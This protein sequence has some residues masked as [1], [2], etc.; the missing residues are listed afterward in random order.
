M[1]SRYN[2][3]LRVRD[4]NEVFL[5]HNKRGVF[6][7]NIYRMYVKDRFHI[8]RSTFFR[9]LTIPYKKKLGSIDN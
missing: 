8:S 3:L 9:Y 1:N 4:V 2:F 7:E 6:S 5:L